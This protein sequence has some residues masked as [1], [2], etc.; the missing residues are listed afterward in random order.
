MVAFHPETARQLGLMIL[1]KVLKKMVISKWCPRAR[2][3][4]CNINTVFCRHVEVVYA[5]N[6]KCP[7]GSGTGQ[8]V[9]EFPKSS[10]VVDKLQQLIIWNY[11]EFSILESGYIGPKSRCTFF[12]ASHSA[13]N[14]PNAVYD[15]PFEPQ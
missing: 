6:T 1:K 3:P 7:G 9:Q 2:R 5:W 13:N 15:I 10:Q 12:P 14:E 8:G 11:L 4:P